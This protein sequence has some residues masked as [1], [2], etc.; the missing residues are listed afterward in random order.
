MY[1]IPVAIF[2]MTEQE[3]KG[4]RITR[5]RSSSI[6]HS[7]NSSVSSSNKD[8]APTEFVTRINAGIQPDSEWGNVDQQSNAVKTI[9]SM[10]G[11]LPADTAFEKAIV[12]AV[13]YLADSHI[14]LLSDYKSLANKVAGI[15]SQSGESV[16]ASNQALQYTRRDTLVVTGIP[17]SAGEDPEQLKGKLATELS[18]SG[19]SV[20]NNDFSAYHRNGNKMIEKQITDR[21]TGDTK[22]IIVPPSVTVRF[23]NSNQKD[24]VIRGY[25]NFDRQKNQ[26]KKIRVFQSITPY[27]SNLKRDISTYFKEDETVNKEILWVHWRSP[28]CGMAVKC[29]D[30]TYFHGIHCMQDL[31][32]QFNN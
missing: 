17:F 30:G 5:S 12:N 20:S 26:P 8:N 24:R 7:R 14:K 22:K 11:A 19:V 31:I 13:N 32:E 28:S 2:M 10:L 6:S 9:Q 21:S 25:K 16:I 15:A 4:Q 29:K 27:Y 3:V 23:K 1:T 18:A